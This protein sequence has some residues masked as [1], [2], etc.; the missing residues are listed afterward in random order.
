MQLP[1]RSAVVDAVFPKLIAARK[2]NLVDN[3]ENKDCLV[4]LYTGRRIVD[5]SKTDPNSIK[6]RNFPLH[7]D[8]MERLKPSSELYASVMAQALAIMHWK[9]G[10]DAND[11]EFVLGSSRMG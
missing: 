4:S 10:G 9:A 8:E 5:R 1:V 11:V 3:G 6:L 7:I 2:D